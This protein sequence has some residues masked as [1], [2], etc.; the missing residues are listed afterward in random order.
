LRPLDA[1]DAPADPDADGVTSQEEAA[2]GTSPV[3]NDTDGD[4]MG[5][6][7]EIVNG[8]NATNP[9]DASGDPDADGLSNV[10]EA[11]AGANPHLNDTDHDGVLDGSD[12]DPAH[13]LAVRL[14]ITF[15][16]VTFKAQPTEAG[17]DPPWELQFVVSI[18]GERQPV[19][20]L[21]LNGTG[22]AG[23]AAN[24]SISFAFDVDDGAALAAVE[25]MLAE[26]DLDETVGVN[27]DD[28][29]DLDPTGNNDTLA[30][31]FSLATGAISGEVTS[32]GADG[33]LDGR[34]GEHDARIEFSLERYNA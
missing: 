26:L 34:N 2:A 21:S 29:L 11:A 22:S 27:A 17:F 30:L 32:G 28:I 7:F 4:G 3:R 1:S 8:L 12:A 31:S 24:L 18:G 14:R 25:I 9:A 16:N 23:Q 5:D 10:A 6:S 13:N 19:V 15:V 33:S 20:N